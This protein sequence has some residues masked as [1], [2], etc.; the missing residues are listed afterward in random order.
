MKKY[1]FLFAFLLVALP[2]SAQALTVNTSKHYFE[3][4]IGTA[5]HDDYLILDAQIIFN[6]VVSSGQRVGVSSFVQRSGRDLVR[7]YTVT[8][9][10]TGAVLFT[11]SNFS[12]LTTTIGGFPLSNSEFVAPTTPG[13]YNLLFGVNESPT[14]TPH[15]GMEIVQPITYQPGSAVIQVV[16]SE[17]SDAI[18]NDNA[19]GADQADPECHTD[20]NAS[21]TLSYVATHDSE[22]TPPNGSCPA[23]PTL[24]LNGRAAFLQAAE[25]FFVAITSKAF[26]GE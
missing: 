2:L 22:T 3:R 24:Q 19:Q 20:C 25:S 13:T 9:S 10:Q 12:A 23:A 15:Q 7:D 17:C 8:V 16:P 6:D 5:N 21:N 18:N 4:I 26:A 1:S 14:Y 11:P